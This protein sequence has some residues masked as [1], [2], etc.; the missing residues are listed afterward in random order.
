MM[1]RTLTA[2]LAVLVPALA[3]ADDT[4]TILHINDLHSRIEP[5]SK[6]NSTCSAEDDAEGKCFGGVARI[7]SA[8]NAARASTNN[9]VL[10]LDGGDQFQGSLFYTHYKGKAAAE[11][12]NTIG[13]DVMA[14]GNH[15]F[16]DGPEVLRDFV[17]AVKFPLV[18]ANAEIADNSPI[19]GLIDPT[20]IVEAG[21]K[22]YGIIGL[23]PQGNATLARAGPTRH[24][25]RPRPGR[26]ARDRGAGGGR[27]RPRDRAQPLGPFGG[28]AH[29]LG[30]VRHRH[31][32]RRSL[33]HAAL[34]RDY[35][36]TRPLS[37]D[38][39]A[40]GRQDAH[41]AGRRLRPLHRQDRPHF[42]RCR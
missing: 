13:F 5:I 2:A 25:H 37:G 29:R 11:F 35:R 16:D 38:G 17:E 4:V 10:L 22:R 36:R 31:H 3:M 28:R 39:G 1:L 27:R 21:G 8:V 30:G 33:P 19:A 9:P 40:A 7:L 15:E 18:M 42:Q 6:Y 12:M 34:Q 41:R 26:D 24:L 32:R 20:T 23:T 14:V